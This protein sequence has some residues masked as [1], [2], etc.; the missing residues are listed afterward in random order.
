MNVEKKY[1]SLSHVANALCIAVGAFDFLIKI[2][3]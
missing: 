3:H 2:I 1:K